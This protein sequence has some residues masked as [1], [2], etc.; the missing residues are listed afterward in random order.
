MGTWDRIK[1]I[2]S[3]KSNKF[4]EQFEDPS[5]LID[6]TIIEAKKEYAQNKA[7]S[8]EVFASVKRQ[9]ELVKDCEESIA[10]WNKAAENAVLAGDDDSASKALDKVDELEG[11]KA[12]LT[13]QYDRIKKQA[14]GL[15][16]KL[17]EQVRE[18]HDAESKAAEIKADAAHA[19]VTS[20]MNGGVLKNGA[21]SEFDRLATKAHNDRIRAEAMDEVESDLNSDDDED[22]LKKY[23]SPSTGGTN[24]RLAELKARMGK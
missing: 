13:A 1:A 22:I 5:E 4:L 20:A 9:E 15:K 8:Q 24:A 16:A 19:K 7:A 2:V 21:L 14:D 23:G 18:I 12:E 17:A 11:R 10:K 6:Q 3:S